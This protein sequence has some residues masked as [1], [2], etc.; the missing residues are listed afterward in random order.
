MLVDLT[1]N[2]VNTSS[3]SF[4]GGLD[5]LVIVPSPSTTA[6]FAVFQNAGVTY[7]SG[8]TLTVAAGQG[9]SVPAA[10]I[11]GHAY[12]QGAIIATAGGAINLSN[13]LTLSGTGQVALGSGTLTVNDTISGMGGQSLAMGSLLVG[14]TGTGS[15]TQTGG[16]NSSTNLYVGNYAGSSGTYTL[17]ASAC[18]P[19]DLSTSATRVSAASYRRAEPT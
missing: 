12:C 17:G 11:A 4:Y 2:V 14:S 5:S 7:V 10:T 18:F 9:F 6:A 1:G 8:S 13:G 15:F 16:T 19:R 3:A